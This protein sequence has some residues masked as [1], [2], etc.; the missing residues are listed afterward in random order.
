VLTTDV[1]SSLVGIDDMGVVW[2][3]GALV[4]PVEARVN[5]VD[6]LTKLLVACVRE[7]I[8]LGAARRTTS[9]RYHQQR[10]IWQDVPERT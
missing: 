8:R 5:G 3:A 4:L 6:L 7:T 9:P 1:A 10:G 2:A